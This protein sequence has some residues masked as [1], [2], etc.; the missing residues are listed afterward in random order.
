MLLILALFLPLP[1]SAADRYWVGGA[2]NWDA[3]AGSK[4]SLT[5]GGAGGQAVPTS[6]DDVYLDAASGAVTITVTVAANTLG[7]DCTGFTGTL[8]INGG[9]SVN[10]YGAFIAAAGMTIPSSGGYLDLRAAAGTPGFTSGG[11]AIN[12]NVRF[13]GAGTYTLQDALAL[14]SSN[15]VFEISGNFDPNGQLVT[16]S[17]NGAYFSVTGGNLSFAGLTVLGGPWKDTYLNVA[18]NI[19]ASGTLTLTGNST[20]NRLYVESNVNGTARTLTAATVAVDKCDLQ[21]MTGAGAGNWNLSGAAG[22]VGDCGGNTGITFTTA[23]N[24]YWHVGSGGLSTVGNWFTAT[25]GG[26]SSPG[27]PPLPQDTAVI[28][29]NSCDA[30]CVLTQDMPR[31]GSITFNDG[32]NPIDDAVTWTTSTTASVFGSITLHA[33][34]VLTASAQTYTYEG[35]G[36]STLTSAGKQWGKPWYITSVTGTLT[37]Q[38]AFITTSNFY[39]VSGTFNGNGQS[40]TTLILYMYAG[41]TIIP[42][43][44]Q[45]S[46]TGTGTALNGAGTMTMTSSTIKFTN[47]SATAITFAGGGKTYNDVWFSRGASAA[48]NTLTG[49]NTMADFRDDGSAAHSILFTPGTT[50][51]VTSF[52][53]SGSAGNLITIGSVGDA[54]THTLSDA[55][56]TNSCNYLDISYSVAQGGATWNA[57]NST[58]SGNNTGWV[59]GGG[60]DGRR[61]LKG[62]GR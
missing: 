2:D 21:D 32:I 27:W 39:I 26:G 5:S 34:V 59:F 43:A 22:G 29:S 11:I 51:V 31:L 35:H 53:V 18:A 54:A 62:V 37:L 4:W 8:T 16:I 19:T 9:V 24:L 6:S 38:D 23:D 3:T 61:S 13:I 58:D 56:G 52:T 28:D 40:I 42:G 33:S 57:I 30:A 41:G 48:T 17:I 55:G 1:L 12:C 49:S 10:V 60:G 45:W 15:G 25:N 47:T 44:G 46:I 50:T 20:V 14:G 36:A 7:L